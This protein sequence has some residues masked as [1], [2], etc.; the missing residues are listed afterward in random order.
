MLPPQCDFPLVDGGA[1]AP[2]PPQA[3]AS[4]SKEGKGF[5]T[6]CSQK[7]GPRRDR[8]QSA[9]IGLMSRMLGMQK[10]VQTGKG[11]AGMAGVQS[12]GRLRGAPSLTLCPDLSSLHANCQQLPS[13]TCWDWHVSTVA[14]PRG[15]SWDS[16]AV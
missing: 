2:C 5:L 7:V 12:R 9:F 8:A 14:I 6:S 16:G 4:A 15:R 11:A 13:A 3:L 10:G 1:P